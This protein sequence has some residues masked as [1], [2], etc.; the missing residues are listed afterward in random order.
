M[1]WCLVFIAWMVS[2]ELE[3]MVVGKSC[4]SLGNNN[5]N[6]S[7]PSLFH[8]FTT[9]VC[10]IEDIFCLNTFQQMSHSAT[11]Y[12]SFVCFQY[13]RKILLHLLSFFLFCFLLAS[14]H[15]S[16]LICTLLF[17]ENY[18]IGKRIKRR[19]LALK[20]VWNHF[21]IAII[22]L[23]KNLLMIHHKH[24]LFLFTAIKISVWTGVWIKSI[25]M[26]RQ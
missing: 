14:F 7:S 24:I 1:V 26:T 8:E 9:R 10:F 15:S 22:I 20:F 12:F 23:T 4:S 3:I 13:T 21:R 18:S 2:K 17:A 25:D 6:I 5:L 16:N 19:D 11:F